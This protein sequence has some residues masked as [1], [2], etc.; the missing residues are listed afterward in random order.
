MPD[1]AS[2]IA[3]PA[4]EHLH[5]P[6]LNFARHDGTTLAGDLTVEQT[7]AAIR[8]G[9]L[10]EKVIYFYVVD[11]EQRLIGVLP[12]RRLLVAPLGQRLDEIMIR[13]VIAIP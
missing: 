8:T 6:V 7:L 1:P 3:K 11:A 12:T 9:G 2:I 10:G 13:N 4:V 5:E